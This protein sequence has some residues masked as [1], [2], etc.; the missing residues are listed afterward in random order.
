MIRFNVHYYGMQ[1]K[2][3]YVLF[4][5]KTVMILNNLRMYLKLRQRDIYASPTL[6]SHYETT[7]MCLNNQLIINKGLCVLTTCK[8]NFRN[9]VNK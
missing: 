7:K 3:L 2:V 4:S 6:A 1:K 9:Y 5:L 8:S